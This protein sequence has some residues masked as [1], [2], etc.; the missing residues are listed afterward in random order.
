MAG[1][2][3][4]SVDQVRPGLYINFKEAA[5]AQITGGERG[6]VAIPLHVWTGGTAVAKKVYTVETEKQASDLFG[7]ANIGPINLVRRGGARTLLVY[8]LPAL[9]PPAVA[10]QSS[11]YTDMRDAFDAYDFNVFVYDKEVAASEQDS[12]LSW[13]AQN[14][15]EG[16]HFSVVFGAS[17]D[18]DDQDP[19]D[20]N[21]RTARLN[22]IYAVNL[23]VGGTLSGVAYGS[24]KYAAYIAGLVAGTPINKSITYTNVAMDDVNRRLTN[25]EVKTALLAGSLVLVATGNVVRVERGLMTSGDKIRKMRARQAIATDLTAAAAANYIGKVDNNED[26]Q[27]A[28]ISAVKAYLETLAAMNV[29]T[30]DITVKLDPNFESKGDKVYLYIKVTEVDSMEE[31]YLTIEAA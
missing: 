28:L 31:I 14:R 3:D 30:A 29:L 2:W 19:T 18:D 26:G 10:L 23:M 7:A 16:K 6:V 27:K 8:T 20:G 21:A 1:S 11:D 25:S 15:E 24:G 22:D 9:V 13:V 17:V 12:A 4:P 5:L